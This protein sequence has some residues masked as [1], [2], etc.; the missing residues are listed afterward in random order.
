MVEEV[1]MVEM[2]RGASWDKSAVKIR[3]IIEC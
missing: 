3:K 2:V 1:A